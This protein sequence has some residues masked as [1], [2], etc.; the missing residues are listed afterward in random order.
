[1]SNEAVKMLIEEGIALATLNK[2]DKLNAMD[3][4]IKAGLM[5][6]IEQIREDPEVKVLV[7]TG[8]GRAFSAGGDINSLAQV[9]TAV[10]GRE[11]IKKL[12]RLVLGLVNL[13]K[14]VIA[15]VNG[16]AV[17]AGCNLALA[18]DIIYASDKARFSEIFANIGLIPDAGGLYFLPRL[19]GLAKAKELVFTARMVEAEEAERIGLIN[20]VVPADR[21]M[22]ETMELARKLAAGPGKALGLAKALLNQSTSWDLPTL[23]E[24]EA[25]AQ[26][27]C[28]QTADFREGLD[29]FLKKRKPQFRG[30]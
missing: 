16:Y 13:E 8:S 17:G 27:I 12:H 18:A 10:K 22:E 3:D 30:E 5:S 24:G 26:G 23:L 1:M 28:M 29:A 19:V 21:L 11:R 15:A 6:V 2:P 25:L 7:I 14:P 20:K 9:N 4:D